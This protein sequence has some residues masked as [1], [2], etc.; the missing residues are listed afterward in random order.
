MLADGSK[1]YTILSGTEPKIKFYF[2]VNAPLHDAADFENVQ[3]QLDAK[4]KGIVEYENSGRL[5]SEGSV[6]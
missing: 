1:I 2:S 4:I 5:K 3:A 6:K